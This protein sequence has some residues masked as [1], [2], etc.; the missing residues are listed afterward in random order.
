MSGKSHP[1]E[2]AC[3]VKKGRKERRKGE[4]FLKNWGLLFCLSIGFIN[5]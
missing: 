1:T 2:E 5:R 4:Q 3:H